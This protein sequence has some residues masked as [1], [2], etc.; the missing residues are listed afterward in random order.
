VAKVVKIIWKLLIIVFVTSLFAMNVLI[1]LKKMIP[2]GFAP[3]VKKK[4]MLKK[5][6]YSDLLKP[7]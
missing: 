6:Y 3:I 1:L 4:M 7:L 5:A 2:P